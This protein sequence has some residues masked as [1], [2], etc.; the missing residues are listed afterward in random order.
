[1]AKICPKCG[2]EMVKVITDPIFH[3]TEYVCPYCKVLEVDDGKKLRNKY[4]SADQIILDEIRR[5][6]TPRLGLQKN[7]E[8]FNKY[9]NIKITYEKF[10]RLVDENIQKIN[11]KI[12]KK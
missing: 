1:M 5:I 2:N 10:C 3:H 8:M 11:V 9:S 6:Y 4:L 7:W 12:K